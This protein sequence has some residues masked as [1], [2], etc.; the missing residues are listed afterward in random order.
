MQ[1]VIKSYD[2]GTGDG[3]VLCDTD[4]RRVRP[5]RRRAR[6]LGLPHAPPGPAGVFDLDD[7]GQA[8]AC[9]SAP[10]STWARRGSRT[11]SQRTS[12]TEPA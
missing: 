6:R 1:G 10:R 11:A 3:V 2:P 12:R 5:R 7:D 9:A 8:T 4:L